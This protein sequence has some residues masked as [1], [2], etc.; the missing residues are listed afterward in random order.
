[1]QKIAIIAFVAAA[2][3]AALAAGL[4]PQNYVQDGLVTH[5][6]AFDN[7]GT[8]THN[9]SATTW[10]D[11]KGSAYITLQ[12]GA[13]WTGRYFDSSAKQ[14][15]IKTMPG[16]D[17]TSVSIE[18]PI[19]V[20]SNGASGKYPR[21]FANSE[22]FG[23]Y[24]S[25]T[26]TSPALYF[27]GQNPDSRPSFGGFRMGSIFA[28]GSSTSYGIGL[29]GEVK[30]QTSV[31]VKVSPTKPAAD[32][33]LSGYSGYLHAHY[34]G[35]R[36]YNRA[37]TAPERYANAAVDGLRFFSFTYTG[38]GA[39]ENWSDIAWTAPERATTTAPSTQTNAYAQL[40]NVTAN[41]TAADNVGLAGL[42]LEDGAKLNLASDV[43][44]AVKA[45]YVEGV[46]VAHGIYT[47]TG[48]FGTQVSWLSGDGVLRVA[49]RLDRR[50]PY[51]VPTPAGDGWYE[52]G[53]A[54]GYSEGV[55]SVV[56][57]RPYWDDYAFPAG[58]KLRL[59]GGILLETV[60]TGMFTEYDTSGLN[61]AYLHGDTAFEDGT[62]LTVPSGCTF[63]YQSGN[64]V[65]DATEPNRW[66]LTSRLAGT[67][68]YAGD[69]VNNGR[70]HV[71]GDSDYLAPYQVFSGNVS[72]NGKLYLTNFGKQARFTGQFDMVCLQNEGMQNGCLVWID[73]LHVG[74]KFTTLN[75]SN[76]D[77]KYATNVS[78][79]ANGLLFGRN[80]SDATADNELKIDKLSGGGLSRIDPNGKRWRVGGH[81][82]V[83][84]GNTVHVGELTSALHVMARRKDQDCTVGWFGSSS[85]IE[86]GTGNI[87]ID[88]LT[89]GT[90]YPSTNVNV[91]VG[92]VVIGSTFDYT[93]QSN[94]VN[95]MT[96]DITNTC[97]ASAIVT[98]TDI[99]MLPARI[100][101]FMGTVTLTDT[102]TKSWTMPI[103]LTHGTDCLYNTTGCIGSGTLGSAP[104]SGTINVT[105]PTTGDKPVK[106][107]YALARFTSGGDK[108][109]GWTVT[110]NGQAVGSAIVSG[111]KVEV[112]KDATGLWLKVREPGVRFII[113]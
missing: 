29:A 44:M 65:L 100:S 106:G 5:F 71:T 48:S 6:D 85:C 49:G 81:V 32:W 8:G 40:I 33:T 25:G 55:T 37:L 30:S 19:N 50:V 52:F 15:T 3:G 2:A 9:P 11:L 91:K 13:S 82:V 72:G 58:A 57:E 113:R 1:M 36:L 67:I 110:L 87:V 78:W 74:G 89:S 63:R 47:G 28:Y 108:L 12:T 7:E 99:G 46:A 31:P 20:I 97:N 60:P 75:F 56:A 42:S 69:V 107:D 88:K 93:Y 101:G 38:T 84:G 66:N 83:W 23:I 14:H 41:V 98:A 105:F 104:A 10:R 76:C 39:A 35:L 103:D 62:P 80:D 68:T 59:V 53:L 24:F 61:L 17:R 96:L 18:V 102:A 90:L 95:R 16:Y 34:Y 43:D 26:G 111:M 86:K 94:A 21:I 4:G 77:G 51:L 73:T 64:F 79:S 54:S 109:A 112:Q 45:L 70:M 92:T 27:N 22:Y